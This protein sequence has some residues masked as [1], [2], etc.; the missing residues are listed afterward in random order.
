MTTKQEWIASQLPN[1][2]NQSAA[3]ICS[4]LNTKRLI[5]NPVPITEIPK[6]VT[7]DEISALLDS[8][9]R[10]KVQQTET[11]K[12]ILSDYAS[13]ISKYFIPNLENLLGGGIINQQQHDTIIA[14]LQQ[15]IPDPSYQS[16]INISPAQEAGFDLVYTD[17]ILNALAAI[18]GS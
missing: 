4:E 9:T 6:P 17:E 12:F 11:W 8:A 1:Y 18:P 15:T 16:Q 5:D 7:V 2:P 10:F 14:L 13:G 3:E